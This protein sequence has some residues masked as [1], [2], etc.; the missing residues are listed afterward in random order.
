MTRGMG[1]E[2]QRSKRPLEAMLTKARGGRRNSGRKWAN[3]ACSDSDI[4]LFQLEST[5]QLW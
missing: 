5:W 2:V 3:G 1:G 4:N